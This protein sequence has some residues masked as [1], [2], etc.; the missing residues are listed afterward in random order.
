MR[1]SSR[2]PY[3]AV[4]LPDLGDRNRRFVLSFTVVNC[5]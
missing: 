4:K 5:S 2:R 3:R 1:E